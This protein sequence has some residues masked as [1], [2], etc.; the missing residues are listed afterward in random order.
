MPNIVEVDAD[1]ED[2]V[3]EMLEEVSEGVKTM[4]QAVE[5][6]DLDT[7]AKA[8]HKIVGSAGGYGFDEL[9]KIAKEIETLSKS[10]DKNSVVNHLAQFKAYYADMEV[11]YVEMDD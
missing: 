8:S 5:S 4:D 1:L 3:P 6:S 2:L 11:K 10:G 7:L 9:A